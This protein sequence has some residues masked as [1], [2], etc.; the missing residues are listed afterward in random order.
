MDIREEA[1]VEAEQRCVRC[2]W[3]IDAV[4]NGTEELVWSHPEWDGEDGLDTRFIYDEMQKWF[5]D[6]AEWAL[7]LE[8]GEAEIE[9]AAESLYQGL[10][11]LSDFRYEIEFDNLAKD[12]PYHQEA[13]KDEARAALRAAR[14]ARA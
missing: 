8:P 11:T 5:A 12:R 3:D 4:R 9:A 14:E 1:R 6:G 7:S 2:N 10:F 13:A